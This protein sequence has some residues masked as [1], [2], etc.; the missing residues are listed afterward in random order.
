MKNVLYIPDLEENLLSVKILAN[1][2][3]TVQ[4]Q[5][6]ECTIRNNKQFLRKGTPTQTSKPRLPLKI[7]TINAQTHVA[8]MIG[9]PKPR[10]TKLEREVYKKI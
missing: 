2:G 3:L 5:D 6:D 7:P 4:F 9:A 8:R 10:K 1:N